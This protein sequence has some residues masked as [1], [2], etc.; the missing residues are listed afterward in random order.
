MTGSNRRLPPCPIWL[1]R[2]LPVLVDTSN[3]R[4]RMA[5]L[6]FLNQVGQVLPGANPAKQECGRTSVQSTLQI[7]IVRRALRR[8]SNQLGDEHGRILRQGD[9]EIGRLFWLPWD[10]VA[11]PGRLAISIAP[12][13]KLG[14]PNA[15]RIWVGH[16]GSGWSSKPR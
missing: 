11:R 6:A 16:P 7:S 5:L 4:S 1:E 2:D 10:A 9:K 8:H 15:V 3:F 14:Y 12:R 13:K